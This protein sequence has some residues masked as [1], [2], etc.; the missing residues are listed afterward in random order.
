M[1]QFSH[2]VAGAAA[3]IAL[4]ELLRQ[5]DV[6]KHL[7][8]RARCARKKHVALLLAGCG[9]YDGSEVQETVSC[10]L[11]LDRCG[12]DVTVFAPDIDQR[13]VIDHTT[14]DEERKVQRQVLIES[15]RI[16]RGKVS[17]LNML[18]VDE[19]DALIIPGGFGV[20]KNL[21]TFAFDSENMVVL[22]LVE[23]ILKQF[24]SQSKPIGFCCIAPVLAGRIFP[25]CQLTV[26]KSSGDGWPYGGTGAALTAMGAKVIEKEANEFLVDT[27]NKFV[28]APAYMHESTPYAIYLNIGQ[29]V[30]AVLKMI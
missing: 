22:P 17:P 30:E 5:R 1:S 8:S 28:S 24:H 29:L 4:Y 7:S 23:K 6:L 19:F 18:Q 16:A 26:G 20:A 9:V 12:V 25:K 10:L 15:A 13:H 14:G 3:G 11:H 21:C 27:V 2:V